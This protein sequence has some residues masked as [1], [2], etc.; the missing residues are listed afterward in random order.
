MCMYRNV[1][2]HRMHLLNSTYGIKSK[3]RYVNFDYQHF[4]LQNFANF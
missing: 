3:L 2:S 1:Y 4:I